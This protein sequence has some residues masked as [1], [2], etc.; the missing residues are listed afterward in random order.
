MSVLALLLLGARSGRSHTGTCA[1]YLLGQ[2]E[3]TGI[4]ELELGRNQQVRQEIPRQHCSFR[5]E[6][7]GQYGSKCGALG[8]SL[9]ELFLKVR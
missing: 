4:A 6:M 3:H 2:Q 5:S 9:R 7:P 8:T 1:I